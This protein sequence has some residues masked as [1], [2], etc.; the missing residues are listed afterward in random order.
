MLFG[1]INRVTGAAGLR[2]GLDVSAVRTRAIADRVAKASLDN[3]D[4]FALS[5]GAGSGGGAA[6]AAGSAGAEPVDVER[7]MVSLGDEQLR[8]EATAKMLERTYA[9]LRT[10][11][12]D[13]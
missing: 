10:V 11:I 2:D 3:G 13:R 1:F 7:E 4:G 12:R 6:T 8:Y 9:Q 5:A